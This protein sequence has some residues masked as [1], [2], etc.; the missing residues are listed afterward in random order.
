M[1]HMLISTYPL[2]DGGIVVDDA[3]DLDVATTNLGNQMTDL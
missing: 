1:A 3:D 2:N